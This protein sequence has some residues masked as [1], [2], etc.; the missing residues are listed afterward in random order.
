EHC[1]A[2]CI[3][4]GR[5]TFRHRDKSKTGPARQGSVFFY[6]GDYVEKFAERFSEYGYVLRAG[7]LIR[8]DHERARRLQVRSITALQQLQRNADEWQGLFE[9]AEEVPERGTAMPKSR[10]DYHQS[11]W[12]YHS[13][14]AEKHQDAATKAYD[15]G[16]TAKYKHHLSQ[17]EFHEEQARQHGEAM[18]ALEAAA[19]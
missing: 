3:W 15:R 2:F 10:H 7:N 6:F 9:A 5:I 18:L 14:R 17:I 8:F 19:E 1:S 11:R 4:K 12:E 13:M 16:N